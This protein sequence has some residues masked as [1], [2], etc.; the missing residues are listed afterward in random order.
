MSTLHMLFLHIL[1]SQAI[2]P[3]EIY[4]S[5]ILKDVQNDICTKVLITVLFITE[6]FEN[7]MFIRGL[8]RGLVQQKTG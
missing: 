1:F 7:E 4:P 2:P 3:L 5:D 6:K 8:N